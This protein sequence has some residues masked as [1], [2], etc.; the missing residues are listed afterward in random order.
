MTLLELCEPLFLKVCELNRM[1]RLGAAQ[2]YLEARPEL[3]VLLDEIQ[4]KSSSDARLA[5]QAK[6]LELPLTFFVDSMIASSQ[7]PFATNWNENR[8][9]KERYNELAGDDRFFDLLLETLEETSDEASER[10]AVFYAC[11]GLGFVGAM[12]GQPQELKKY[13]GQISPRIRHLMD[14]DTK[15]RLCPDA[16]N[17]LDTRNLVEPPASPLVLVGILFLFLCVST[18]VAYVGMYASATSQLNR[19]IN[20]ILTHGQTR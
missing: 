7:L 6:K 5:A 8:L 20:T 13:M 3:K 10:L 14:L 17:C 15:A 9:A 18:L 4:Q 16:Y 11:L 2:D 1:A 12:V 19:A